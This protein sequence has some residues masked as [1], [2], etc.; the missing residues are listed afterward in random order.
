MK[1]NGTCFTEAECSSRGGTNA[2][3]CASGFGVCCVSKFFLKK[4]DELFWKFLNINVCYFVKK[5]FKY[6]KMNF[7][8]SIPD[9]T[10]FTPEVHTI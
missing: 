6:V 1:R 9:L 5:V 10:N 3:S 4:S 2:G 7:P 8:P